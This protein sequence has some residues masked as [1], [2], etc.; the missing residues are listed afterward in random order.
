MPTETVKPA[1]DFVDQFH[2]ALVPIQWIE[3]GASGIEIKGL[4]GGAARKSPISGLKFPWG[5]DLESEA[6]ADQSDNPLGGSSHSGNCMSWHKEMK[7][8]ILY[9][10]FI[11]AAKANAALYEWSQLPGINVQLDV[12]PWRTGLLKFQPL[13]DE[14]QAAAAD[15][16]LIVLAGSSDGSATPWLKKWLEQWANGRRIADAAL[17]VFP[18]GAISFAPISDLS[19]LA[20]FPDANADGAK[21]QSIPAAPKE[22]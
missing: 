12:H 13:A 1:P 20:E 16:H 22:E 2:C 9:S 3:T 14:A 11:H 15:A 5:F 6:V 17:A 7:V 19:R 18:G 21:F 4:R 10:E 8:I